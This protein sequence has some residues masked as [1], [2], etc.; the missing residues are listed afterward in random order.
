MNTR[1]EKVAKQIQ[2]D[3]A[4]ILRTHAS[5]ISGNKMLTVTNVRISPDLGV[6]RVYISVFP[7]EGGQQVV[8]L[9]N[10]HPARLRNDL[11]KKIRHQLRKVPQ[12]SFFLDDSLDYIDNINTLLKN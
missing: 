8:D 10:E 1:Q 2:K 3:L 11:G 4:E 7:S 6:A 9:L 12:L 5:G